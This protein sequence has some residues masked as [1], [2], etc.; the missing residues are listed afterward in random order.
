[1]PTIGGVLGLAIQIPDK[2]DKESVND[3]VMFHLPTLAAEFKCYP[4]PDSK[5]TFV[6]VIVK[7]LGSAGGG[8]ADEMIATMAAKLFWG[9]SRHSYTDRDETTYDKTFRRLL[10]PDAILAGKDA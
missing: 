7:P 6:T 3:W 10:W 4:L 9:A 2:S 5:D 1:M 8:W